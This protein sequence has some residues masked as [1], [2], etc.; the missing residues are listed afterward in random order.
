MPLH[1]N[2]DLFASDKDND[3]EFAVVG[4]EAPLANGVVDAFRAAGLRNFGPTQDAAQ[5]ESSK[6]Y[7]K[8]FMQRHHID[9][10]GYQRFTDAQDPK[11][12]VNERRAPTV[13]NSAGSA[14]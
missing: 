14:A 5:L 10:A 13:I 3:I 11:D 2:E 8:D 4:P 9:T 7:A 12:Y 1:R 6:E